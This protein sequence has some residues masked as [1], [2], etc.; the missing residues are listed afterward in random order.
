L[1]IALFEELWGEDAARR[2]A[3]GK[4]RGRR[5]TTTTIAVALSLCA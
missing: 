1:L 5:G 3:T 4:T 2:K